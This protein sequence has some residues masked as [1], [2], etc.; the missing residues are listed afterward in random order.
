[1]TGKSLSPFPTSVTFNLPVSLTPQMAMTIFF[2]FAIVCWIIYTLVAVYHWIK[3]SHASR[4]AYPA[5][6]AHLIISIVLA[7]YTFSGLI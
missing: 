3:Y 2:W 5:I 7:S 4:V 1:M 6:T